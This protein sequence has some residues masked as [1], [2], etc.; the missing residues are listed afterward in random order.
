ME[1]FYR[2]WVEKCFDMEA[3][4]PEFPYRCWWHTLSATYFSD[5]V[6]NESVFANICPFSDD[7]WFKAMALYN[8]KLCKKVYT[9]N[10]SG[11]DYLENLSVQN[12][13]LSY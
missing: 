7:I 5:E 3:L 2:I 4:V 13:A 6:F 9:H 8:D 10:R 11:N 12:C 1:S